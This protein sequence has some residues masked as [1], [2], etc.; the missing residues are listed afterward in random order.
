M[1][2]LVQLRVIE[3]I[4]RRG[5]VTAAAKDLHFTQPSLS[6]HVARLEAETGARLLQ[7]VGRGIRLTE[8]G[9]LLASRASEIVGRVDAA[10]AELTALVGLTAGRVRLAGFG[11]VMS[12]LVPAA[13]RL[14]TERHPGLELALTDTHPE[15]AL[16]LLRAGEIELAIIFRYDETT[17]EEDGVR[18]VHLLDDPL[19]LLSLDGAKTLTE[20]RD[21]PWIGGCERCRVHLLELCAD[22]GF[23]PSLA[24][25]TDD[26]VVMQSMVAAGLGVTTIPGLAL[27]AHRNPEVR[28]ERLDVSPRRIFAAT[29]G[30]PPDPPATSAVVG[31]L[32][33]AARRLR[34]Q[35]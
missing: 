19:H 13:T 11:S 14:L 30:S 1:V 28:A 4:G 21:S 7:R 2:T 31:A 3:A 35:G 22:A 9:E 25:N 5:S 33:D 24:A 23:T 8:A 27:A 34:E 16:R 17:P 18:L 20:H 6:H 26:S 29:Y 12:S 10:A 32:R 15:D